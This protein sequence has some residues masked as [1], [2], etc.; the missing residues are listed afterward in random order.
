[1]A[2]TRIMPMHMNKGKTLLQSI[3]DRT[4]YAMNPDKTDG[5]LL[6][7]AYECDPDSVE[8][9]FL[10]AKEQYRAITGRE[11]KNGKDVIAY[12]LRQSFYP[13]EITP[14]EA[15]RMGYELARRFTEGKHQFIVATCITTSSSIPLRWTAPISSTTI[16]IPQIRC[17]M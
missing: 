3:T 7:S 15:N 6:V 4:D 17:G 1:M 12:H 5:G 9:D 8:V 14:E 13:G 16:R 2:T 11:P 10:L